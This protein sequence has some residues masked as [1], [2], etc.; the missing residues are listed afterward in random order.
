MADEGMTCR[1]CGNGND[2]KRYVVREMMFGTGE[3][4][5]YFEC[6]SCG[7]LQLKEIPP[8]MSRYYP[9]E[10]YSFKLPP[11]VRTDVKSDPLK[12]FFQRERMRHL[13]GNGSFIGSL[14]AR[15]W[16][17]EEGLMEYTGWLKSCKAG[18]KSRIL[19]VGSGNGKVLL[20]LSWYGFED[21]T[22][23]DP[24]IDNDKV[25]GKTLRILKRTIREAEGKFDVIMLHHSLEHMPDQKAV[26]ARIRELLNDGGRA[27]VRV[28]TV[29]SFAFRH[30]A[31]DWAQIDAPRHIYLHSIRS[32]GLLALGY[33]L[34]ISDLKYDST[35]F[36]FWAS[37]QYRRGIPLNDQRSY[38]V[39]PAKSIFRPEDIRSYEKR[40]AELNRE[41]AGD[42]ICAY[43]SKA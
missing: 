18:L 42:Q 3:E 5:A 10:Y 37:E 41:G 31:S 35:A 30:Y 28:P 11:Y 1:I 7:C 23:I 24:F 13:L 9:A 19:D 36:Q 8:D 26:F 40:A 38:S 32:L 2:N 15:A 17:P 25:Y 4:F 12:R 39:D 16:P 43:L 33:G 21:L 29:S 34:V 22:G 27:I 6:S 14:A 20:E